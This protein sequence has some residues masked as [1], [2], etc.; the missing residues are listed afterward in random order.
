MKKVQDSG[1]VEFR[2]IKFGLGRAFAGHRVC[3]LD[4]GKSVQIFDLA[5]T[6]IVEHPW[7]KPGVTYVSNGRP[8]GHGTSRLSEMS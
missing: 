8:R 1:S 2:G 5:G 6:L 4:A 3:V 7:P